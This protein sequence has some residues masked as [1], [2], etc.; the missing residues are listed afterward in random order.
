MP[1]GAG[2]G[3]IARIDGATI[4]VTLGSEHRIEA[5]RGLQAFRG[6]EPIKDP[7]SGKVLGK[8]HRQIAQLEIIDVTGAKLSTAKVVGKPEAAVKVG[9]V[10]ETVVAKD[11]VAILPLVDVEG[12]EL[13][14]GENL[15]EEW[16][17]T[18]VSRGVPV[19]ERKP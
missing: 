19:V 18:L 15:I 8:Q 10:V 16:M 5:G 4:Y 2:I 14:E 3:K 11:A 17:T 12:N 13:A 9:D 6:E 7:T 1:H